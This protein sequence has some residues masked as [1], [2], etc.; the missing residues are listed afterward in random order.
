MQKS[1]FCWTW[2]WDLKFWLF[3]EIFQPLENL[4]I[5]S[6]KIGVWVSQGQPMIKK[7]LKARK[8]KFIEKIGL[9]FYT[10]YT[11]HRRSFTEIYISYEKCIIHWE[12]LHH[13]D[14]KLKGNFKLWYIQLYFKSFYNLVFNAVNPD[15]LKIQHLL[16]NQRF[17]HLEIYSTYLTI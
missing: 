9:Y 13:F 8:S 1:R 2:K 3:R 5:R 15:L 17:G 14:L 11:S 10:K 12:F 16:R 6:K 7:I 4:S